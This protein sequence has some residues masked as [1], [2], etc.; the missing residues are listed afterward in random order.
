[1][2]E[3]YKTIDELLSD[4][5]DYSIF[6]SN[7]SLGIPNELDL[8]KFFSN[9]EKHKIRKIVLTDVFDFLPKDLSWQEIKDKSF[10]EISGEYEQKQIGVTQF[11]REYYDF[12]NI[13]NNPDA[14]GLV[15]KR[16]N[17][18]KP[19]DILKKL[20][21]K[22]TKAPLERKEDA[23]KELEKNLKNEQNEN[24]KE[25]IKKLINDT[26]EE[27]KNLE[28]DETP[29]YQKKPYFT[30][31][32]A[33]K[34]I[35]F[36]KAAK[37]HGVKVL[38]STHTPNL[39]PINEK[40]VEIR[41]K[42]LLEGLMDVQSVLAE[43]PEKFLEN[44]G[45]NE[46]LDDVLDNLTESYQKYDLYKPTISGLKEINTKLMDIRGSFY[47]IASFLRERINQ[48]KANL[49]EVQSKDLGDEEAE[50]ETL[51]LDTDKTI[52]SIQN[53]LEGLGRQV[54]FKLES[55]PTIDEAAFKRM[56]DR[57]EGL[58]DINIGIPDEDKKMI[59]EKT[60][61]S[62]NMGLSIIQHERLIEPKENSKIAV[63]AHPLRTLSMLGITTHLRAANE[64]T[65]LR[66]TSKENVTIIDFSKN[67]KRLPNEVE[68]QLGL[69][70]FQADAQID[71][72][73]SPEADG[74]KVA[75]VTGNGKKGHGK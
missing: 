71:L 50:N 65:A 15:G 27:I 59:A 26:K 54:S 14:H 37:A 40:L 30:K 33:T 56:L 36:V 22:L 39:R 57:V 29:S 53:K 48:E 4:E 8:G 62:K 46:I 73:P 31:A 17:Y 3:I 19:D 20:Y 68:E 12:E 25:V 58:D 13:E 69:N 66:D 75:S 5:D 10:D 67:K 47:D 72:N 61:A 64:G 42:R 44:T 60:L 2:G 1:M 63:M 28:S 32:D 7:S 24:V 70:H 55:D 34:L 9:L 52:E 11:L 18:K 45:W 51:I 74:S 35:E 43:I 23:L 16:E 49:V 21:E 38:L 6:C 41:T